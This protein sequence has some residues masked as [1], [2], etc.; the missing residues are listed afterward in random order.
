M[1]RHPAAVEE[2]EQ[3]VVD[4][5]APSPGMQAQSACHQRAKESASREVID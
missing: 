5:M 4:M 1:L 3:M 2:Q